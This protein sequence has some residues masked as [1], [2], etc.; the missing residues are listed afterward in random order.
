[1]TNAILKVIYD[2]ARETSAEGYVIFDFRLSDAITTA[3]NWNP[4]LNAGAGGFQAPANPFLASFKVGSRGYVHCAGAVTLNIDN[5]NEVNDYLLHEGGHARFLYHHAFVNE[6]PSRLTATSA[7]P[8]HHDGNNLKC[9]MSYSTTTDNGTTLIKHYCG[10]CLL[11]LRG[12]NIFKLPTKY[13]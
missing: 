11:R 13:K 6:A 3:K 9:T 2:R 5:N 7:N 4:A 1:M 8:T 12:W 10:K